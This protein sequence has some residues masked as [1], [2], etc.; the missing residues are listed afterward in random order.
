MKRAKPDR[1]TGGTNDVNPQFWKQELTSA[2]NQSIPPGLSAFQSRVVRPNLPVNR[3][4]QQGQNTATIIEI[5]KVKWSYGYVVSAP[6]GGSQVPYEGNI[7]G[8]LS[9]SDLAPGG[10]FAGDASKGSVIDWFQT[11]ESFSPW[12]VAPGGITFSPQV[13]TPQEQPVWHDLTDGDGHGVLVAT[14]RI[15]VGFKI[16]LTSN[17]GA[18]QSNMIFESANF[19][20]EMLYRYKT[21]S[22]AEFIGIVQSQEGGA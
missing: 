16:T 8:Y 9:T 17:A 1:L 22:L 2:Q 7:E 4:N 21:V 19:L 20:F 15:N 10:T 14:D 5:L 11:T 6:S 12:F 3:I 13:K 18:G